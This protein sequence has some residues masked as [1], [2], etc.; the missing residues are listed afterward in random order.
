M[1]ASECPG[2][3]K[4]SEEVPE[5][6]N[7]GTSPSS[8]FTGPQKK[9]G[10]TLFQSLVPSSFFFRN[11]REQQCGSSFQVL[12]KTTTRQSSLHGAFF[13][14]VM[15]Y[16]NLSFLWVS[17]IFSP[18]FLLKKLVVKQVKE[19]KSMIQ[20][21]IRI[22]RKFRLGKLSVCTCLWSGHLLEWGGILR[23]QEQSGLYNEFSHPGLYNK[24]LSQKRKKEG[25][26]GLEQEGE[27][28]RQRC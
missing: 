26:W 16:F 8:Y 1:C 4:D 3:W 11:N 17:N 10:A 5:Q 6:I 15:S 27:R 21:C 25:E 23:A 18:H 20:V 13:M 24:T 7:L 28:A 22:F 19:I 12:G 9:E 14:F 2:P